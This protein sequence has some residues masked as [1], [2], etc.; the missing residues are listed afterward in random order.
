MFVHS[1]CFLFALSSRNIRRGFLFTSHIRM[2]V[3]GNMD[4]ADLCGNLRLEKQAGAA[5]A[6]NI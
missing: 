3:K 4:D 6:A 2:C 1:V 5:A